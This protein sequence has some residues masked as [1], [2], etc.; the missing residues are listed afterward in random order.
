MFATI[1]EIAL[2]IVA[3]LIGSFPYMAILS[4]IK[5]I[6]VGREEDYHLAIWQKMGRLAGLSGIA[7]DVLKGAIPILI[8]F[9]F[10]FRLA[11]TVSAGIA[12]VI[13]QM[14]P[15]F[16]RFNGGK[17]NTTGAGMALVLALFLWNDALLVFYCCLFCFFIGFLVR[18]IRGFSKSGKTIDEKLN[19][20]GHPSNSMPLGMLA[21]F[22]VLPIASVIFNQPL[23]MTI[24]FFVMV[25]IIIIRRL[26]SNL[27]TDLK[28]TKTSVA[29]IL[30]NR[31]LFDRSHY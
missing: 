7:V 20:G 17:G 12:S 31:F 29:K 11:I 18:I 5:G 23:E 3:Y 27:D 22:V 30:L 6:Y 15:V 8:G 28:K 4:R 21:G 24:C 16:Q 2:I 10:D 25:I 9:L 26:T 19:I 13:G 14:W 1:E